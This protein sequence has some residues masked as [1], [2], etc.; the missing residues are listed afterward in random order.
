M[1]R[2]TRLVFGLIALLTAGAATATGADMRGEAK[3]GYV[4]I[5]EEGNPGV[6]QP[7]FNLYEGVALSLEDFSYV[8]DNGIR[9]TG[10]LKNITLNN[11]NLT[12][13]ATKSGLF[14][15]N[16]RNNQYRRIYSLDGSRFT[17]RRHT[18][19]DFWAQ[20]HKYV[21]VF[22]G[23]GWTDRQGDQ[24]ERFDIAD[25]AG[26]IRAL[27]YRQ[28]YYHAGVRLQQEQRRLQ[29]E[30]RG[31][32][33]SEDSDPTADRTTS[34]FRVTA[35]A[36]VPRYENVTLYGGYQHYENRAD[37]R[38]DTLK[39]NTGWLG[40]T[41]YFGPGY[42]ARYN[43]IWDR[44]RRTG[45]LSATDNIANALYV[46]RTW[47][48]RGGVTLGYRNR[49]NDDVHDEV[50]AVGWAVSGW[51]RPI[52]PLTL[53]A[54]FGTDEKEVTEGRTLTGDIEYTRHFASA[55]YRFTNGS[56]ARLQ[57]AGRNQENDEI[58]SSFDYS[59][60]AAEVFLHHG[61]YG[62]LQ[63]SYAL[64]TG[65]YESNEEQFEF[66]DHVIAGDLWLVERYRVTAGVG[67]TYLRSKQ[68]LDVES[69]SV[70]ISG[71]YALTARERIE[72]VYTAHNFDDLADQS[73]V[74]SQYYTANVVELTLSHDL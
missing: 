46:G 4:Y 45:D 25:G 70:R 28:T 27:D 19:G 64:L 66:C 74:Y 18:S 15:V 55:T 3:A 2:R 69:F 59:R 52:T 71:K 35:D 53:R 11:R 22:G 43:F 38:A 41:W 31:G 60:L 73:P 36:P 14:G 48:G 49:V 10:D 56:Q 20:P 13:G 58:G 72:L 33:Y 51:F 44:T 57:Y 23:Y 50:D 16:L 47:T 34:R 7:T 9:F 8:L 24:V 67:G 42:H 68:D 29:V 40:G 21:R 30:F 61:V 5:D 17:R 65:E 54:G 12:A 6:N 39:A 37:E 62:D 32:K 26:A 1:Y 63:V